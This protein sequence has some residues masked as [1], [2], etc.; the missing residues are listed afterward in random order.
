M[1]ARNPAGSEEVSEAP[2]PVSDV[3]SANVIGAGV[4]EAGGEVAVSTPT[5][6]PSRAATMMKDRK[7]RCIL[8]EPPGFRRHTRACQKPDIC[9][10]AY[11]RGKGT[12]TSFGGKAHGM[13]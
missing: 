5:A 6:E 11:E 3:T 10:A 13:S 9:S 12:S 8:C 1:R 4:A 7:R 2:G